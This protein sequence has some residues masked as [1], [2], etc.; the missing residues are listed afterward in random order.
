MSPHFS[1]RI[2]NS[3]TFS[4]ETVKIFFTEKG[5]VMSKTVVKKGFVIAIPPDIR[6]RVD[7]KEGDQLLIETLNGKAILLEKPKVRDPFEECKGMWQ[8][9]KETKSGVRYV[10]KIREE[11][12]RRLERK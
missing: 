1:R 4:K 6:K 9:R 10:R 3:L 7:F 5:K 2:S 11:S 12:D 8:G